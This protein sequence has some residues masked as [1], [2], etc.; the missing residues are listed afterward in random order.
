MIWE[1][2]DKAK[3]DDGEQIFGQEVKEN[4]IVMVHTMGVFQHLV[5][6]CSCPGHAERHI[7]LLRLRLFP[8]SMKR[9]S[10]V[11]SFNVLDYFYIDAMECK[12]PGQ[13]FFQKLHC[14][15]NNAFPHMV[16]VSC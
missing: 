12:T 7:Q 2:G 3:D 8:T 4:V 13:S 6:W 11:F 14:L 9:P 1:D 10:T 15:T 5:C 16:P